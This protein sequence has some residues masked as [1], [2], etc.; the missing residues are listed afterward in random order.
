MLPV[1]CI[2]NLR[3]YHNRENLDSNLE[4]IGK[5]TMPR[6]SA[7]RTRQINSKENVE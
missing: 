7:R 5:Y 3:L 4:Y 1:H 2:A 6:L